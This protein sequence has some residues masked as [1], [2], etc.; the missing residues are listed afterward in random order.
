MSDIL[1]GTTPGGPPGGNLSLAYLCLDILYDLNSHRRREREL[2][3]IEQRW[4]LFCQ[5]SSRKQL[6]LQKVP[7]VC[8]FFQAVGGTAIEDGVWARNWQLYVAQTTW[9]TDYAMAIVNAAENAAG[10]RDATKVLE[11]G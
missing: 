6:A 2:L 8:S 3:V 1:T 9:E 4:R 10:E 7:N 11:I 5:V